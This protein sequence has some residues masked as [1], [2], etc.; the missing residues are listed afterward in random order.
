M[1]TDQ[2]LQAIEERAKRLLCL[3]NKNPLAFNVLSL[4]QALR[5]ECQRAERAEAECQA[6]RRVV[7]ALA[8]SEDCEEAKDLM[9]AGNAWIDAKNALAA[10]RKEFGK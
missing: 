5:E 4:C 6:L 1:L 10:W 3:E 2:E 7:V 8:S 9:G